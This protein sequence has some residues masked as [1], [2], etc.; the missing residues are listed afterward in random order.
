[1][2][3]TYLIQTA[4]GNWGRGKSLVEAAKNA[5]VGSKSVQANVF[6]VS[7]LLVESIWCDYLGCLRFK[8]KD[9]MGDDTGNNASIICDMI[10]FGAYTMSLTQTGKLTLIE[11]PE[12]N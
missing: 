5:R 2:D 6:S 10:W 8:T 7:D 9:G 3:K 11:L 4:A 12:E 1:M